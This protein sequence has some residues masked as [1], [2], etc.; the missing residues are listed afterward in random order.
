M[1]N[2]ST[3]FPKPTTVSQIRIKNRYHVFRLVLQYLLLFKLPVIQY[4]APVAGVAH[5]YSQFNTNLLRLELVS[6]V[7][8]E[9]FNRNRNF[10]ERQN[11]EILE[12]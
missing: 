3:R 9:S 12:R 11:V 4:Y 2:R 1:F 7:V 8:G 5:L 10:F 6:T